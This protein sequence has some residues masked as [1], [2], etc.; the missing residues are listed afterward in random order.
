[1]SLNMKTAIVTGASGNMGRAI[2]QKFLDDGYRVIGAVAANEPDSISIQH[3]HFEKVAID[4]LDE[5]QASHF[6]LSMIDKY[7]CIDVVILTVGGFAMGSIV[8]T[9]I[10]SVMKQV[11]LNF[12]TTYNIARPVFLQMLQ[13]GHGRIF[14]TGS[15]PGLHSFH[16]SG[17]VAYSLGK[18]LLFRLADLMNDEAKGKDVVAS[19]IVPSTIDT[20]Q[21]RQ[22]MPDADPSNWVTPEEIANIIS[23][24]CSE[25][26]KSLRETVIKIYGNS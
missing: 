15:R 1:M 10:A 9:N 25:E 23:Y 19:I 5:D 24:H 20:P 8:D 3:G 4:L 16:G 11:N 12:S 18:S 17:M 13:H 14:M 26:A 7:S 22:A 2:V 6:I 21:N